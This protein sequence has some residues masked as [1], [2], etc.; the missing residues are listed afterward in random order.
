MF[1]GLE[2]SNTVEAIGLGAFGSVLSIERHTTPTAFPV[3]LVRTSSA[4]ENHPAI[5]EERESLDN[6]PSKARGSA[7]SWEPFGEVLHYSGSTLD[8]RLTYGTNQAYLPDEASREDHNVFVSAA[9]P[10]RLSVR[11]NQNTTPSRDRAVK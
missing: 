8:V 6:A 1:Y 4:G 5:P 2:C 7:S 10:A 3:W 9:S 11:R